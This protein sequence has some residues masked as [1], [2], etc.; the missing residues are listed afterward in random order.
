MC[1]IAGYTGHRNAYPILL[2][3]LERLE[4]RGYDSCGVA[5]STK[6]GIALSKR[7]GFVGELRKGSPVEAGV[8]GIGHTRWAT[9]GKP[10]QLNA[11]PHVSC[12]G[13]TAIV[14]NGDIDNF[15]KLRERLVSDGHIFSSET[16]SEVLAHLIESHSSQGNIGSV[17]H[18]LREIEGTYALAVAFGGSNRIIV[19]R[20]ENPLVLGVGQGEMYIASDTPAIIDHTQEMIYLEDGDVAEV[21]P[22]DYKIFHDEIPVN[23]TV[24]QMPKQTEEKGLAGYDHYFL[25]EVH[26]QPKV[27]RETLAGRISSIH[28]GIDL[29]LNRI[30]TGQ[31]RQVFIA[32]CGS[33]FHA[34]LIGQHFFSKYSSINVTAQIASEITQL[35]PGNQNDLGIFVTQSGETADTLHAARLA[36]D[37]GYSTIGL[38]NTPNSSIARI[39]DETILTNAGLEISV[40]ASKSLT[41]Q[42]VDLF[43]LGLLLFP[44]PADNFHE[45]LKE[46]RVLPAKAQQVLAQEEQFKRIGKILAP[47]S[48]A[49]VVAKGINY[50]VALEASLKLKELAYLHAEAILA[51]ELKH[52]PLAL[53]TKDTPVIVL[54]PK[55]DSYQRVLQAIKEMRARGAPTIVFTDTYDDTLASLVDEIVYLPSTLQSFFPILMNIG[56]QLVAYYCALER[57]SSIDRP[58]NL[59]KSVTVH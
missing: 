14:H 18:A 48:S 30:G 2:D 38:T 7:P 41:A 15:Y 6:N 24:H 51:G 22:N 13:N 1:G 3:T 36:R 59:A 49:Y 53:L 44:P 57:N 8:C 5:I 52:G 32:G 26:Q 27:I 33:A 56:L 11:H 54:A 25:K 58:R 35:R 50:A 46:M 4:Y 21:T 16:D 19:A 29:K 47:N 31:V 42:L 34:S 20:R 40:A 12:D 28:P 55:D 17:V 39:T 23:R 45:L 10:D 43:L 37:A 9:V